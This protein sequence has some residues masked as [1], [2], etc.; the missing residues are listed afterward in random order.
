[1][2][3]ENRYKVPNLERALLIIEYLVKQPKGAGITAIADELGFPKNSVFRILKTLLGNGYLVESENQYQLSSKFLAIGY[4][5]IGESN[6]VAKALDIMVELR[7]QTHETALLGKLSGMQGL[8]L[9]VV[10]SDQ[11]VKFV[12]DVGHHF[13]LHTSAPGKVFLAYLPEAEQDRLLNAIDYQV[14]TPKTIKNR[15]EME[16]EIARVRGR[17]CAFDR[18]ERVD[19]A[20]CVAAPIFDYRKDNIA[21][22]WVT[23][24]SYR[25]PE[26]DLERLAEIVT[27]HARR[28]SRIMGYEP[29]ILQVDDAPVA[30]A[31]N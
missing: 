1:M 16:A 18:G 22:L 5:S 25:M 28:L 4:A 17:G 6:L 23:G 8:V 13:Q 26:S 30:G 21:A 24:P 20:H 15:E 11:S 2:E 19:T 14:H 3:I 27:D 7:N 10:L 9:E 29:D 31:V 12:V